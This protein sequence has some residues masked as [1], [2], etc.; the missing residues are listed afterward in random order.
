[1]RNYASCLSE[2]PECLLAT[3]IF[4]QTI[5]NI[6]ALPALLNATLLALIS[7]S[8]PLVMTFTTSVAA[9]DP[10]G[11]ISFDVS[12]RLLRKA[13][14]IHVVAVSSDGCIL[15]AESEGEFDLELWEAVVARIFDHDRGDIA[16][17]RNH[18]DPRMASTEAS[19]LDGFVRRAVTNKVALEQQWQEDV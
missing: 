6:A 3:R 14:S 18:R 5:Q 19:S 15:I 10:Q 16:G 9:V 4:V 1:M 11:E 12:P 7:T 13:N 8:I 17:V 2:S